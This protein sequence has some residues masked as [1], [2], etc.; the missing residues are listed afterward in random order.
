[1][2]KPDNFDPKTVPTVVSALPL[3]NAIRDLLDRNDP[4]AFAAFLSDQAAPDIADVLDRLDSD[5]RESTFAMMA[6]PFAAAVLAEL[7][8]EAANDVLSR[9]SPDQA[10]DLLEFLPV[11]DAAT[12][13]SE[14]VPEEQ[15][16]ELLGRMEPEVAREVRA[17]LSYPE[18]SIGRLMTDKF[19]GVPPGTTAAGIIERLR[20]ADPDVET[21]SDVY[22]IDDGTL[23]GVASLR[24]VIV[25]APD[26]PVD[27]FMTKRVVSIAPTEDQ[28]VAARLV[29]HYDFLVLP[30]VENGKLLGIVTVD[31]IVDV[32][33]EEG[34]EDQLKFGAVE[35]GVLTQPYFTTPIWRVVRSRVGWLLLLFVAETATGTVL[36]YF[37]DELARVVALSFFIPLLIGTGGNTGA[38]T[39]STI[40]RGIALKEIRLRDTAR[41]VIRE[42]FSGL[43]L[44]VLLATVGFGRAL[45]WGS[46]ME[47]SM[48]VALTI[49]A[50]VT[51]ANTIGSLIPLLAQRL[52]IDPALISAPLITTL[53]DASGLAIYL[54]IAKALLTALR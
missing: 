26:S 17:L 34:T 5:E 43:L 51:W 44:G 41:V 11:D 22:V 20:A 1:M 30:I 52:R 35:P 46:G 39:V 25:A 12:V 9:L 49:I 33:I 54:L 24:Q 15:T 4:A 14:D 32:L 6:P 10:A 18:H 40:I 37:E 48:V 23:L 7:G 45:V 31:D 36:R 16:E 2:M 50:I 13:L 38:Q 53:V 21:F 27:E 29:A 47:L 8:R 19:V 42:L 28:E 3:E